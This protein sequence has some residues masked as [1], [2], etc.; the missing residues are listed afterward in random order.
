[1]NSI[2]LQIGCPIKAPR[3]FYRGGLADFI[4]NKVLH[5][6]ISNAIFFGFCGLA[7]AIFSGLAWWPVLAA[8]S[9]GFIQDGRF[10]PMISRA[11]DP[12][13]FQNK[14]QADC[15]TAITLL[16]GA[17]ALLITALISYLRKR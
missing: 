13:A 2:P 1:M 4:S 11:I 3:K 12:V 5:M 9:S 6:R 7:T 17:V 10:S 16:I 15:V 14:Y 8:K